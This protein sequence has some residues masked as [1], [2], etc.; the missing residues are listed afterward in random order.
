[1]LQK[2][3]GMHMG[4]G[5]AYGA[6]ACLD[7]PFILVDKGLASSHN[8]SIVAVRDCFLTFFL[9]HTSLTAKR[10]F[11]MRR[12]EIKEKNGNLSDS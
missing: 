8:L 11:S 2:V 10:S 12:G 6:S 4:L 5:C 7:L 1:M 9:K 3:W